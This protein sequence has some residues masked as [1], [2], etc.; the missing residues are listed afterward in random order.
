MAFI[1]AKGKKVK[2]FYLFCGIVDKNVYI[3]YIIDIQ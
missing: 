1:K 2:S 3:V